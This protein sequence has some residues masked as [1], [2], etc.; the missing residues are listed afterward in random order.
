MKLTPELY[1]LFDMISA[2]YRPKL[3]RI[4]EDQREY[5]MTVFKKTGYSDIIKFEEFFIW[6]YHFIYTSATDILAGKKIISIPVDG[7]F[8][9]L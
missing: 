5:S 3:L 2:D 1:K 6:W 8:Y 4:L 7:N 9:Y